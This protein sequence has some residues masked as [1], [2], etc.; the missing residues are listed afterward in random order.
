M[1][2]FILEEREF[3]SFL[4][5][6]V[7]Y[8]ISTS[9]GGRITRRSMKKEKAISMMCLVS[10]N[11]IVGS[12]KGETLLLCPSSFTKYVTVKGILVIS[13]SFA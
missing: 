9:M 13:M 3:C 6:L 1:A 11:E 4:N 10:Q 12:I 7:G 5:S 2:R 8:A